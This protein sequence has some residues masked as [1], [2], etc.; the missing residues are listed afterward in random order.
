MA[1]SCVIC[2]HVKNSKGEM[3]ESRLFKGLLHHLADRGLAKEYYAV[4]T[5]NE[6]LKRVGDAAEFDENGEITVASLIKTAKI[7]IAKEK[8]IATLNEDIGA[9]VYSY[10]DAIG[11]LQNFNR[12]SPF[13]GD[14]MATVTSTGDGNYRL[15]VVERTA[16]NEGR[17]TAE[18]SNRT[19]QDRI[20]Y[21]LR[22]A[23]V[24]VDFIEADERI[25]GRYSTK[26]AKQTANG[27]YQLIKVAKGE[28]IDSSLAEEAGHFAVGALGK[29][30]LVQRFQKLLTPEVQKRILGE[31][32]DEKALG[33]NAAREVAGTL[34]GKALIGEVSNSV[35]GR[36]L[37]DRIVN[38][39]KKIFA[40]VKGDEVMKAALEADEIAQ[41]IAKDFLSPNFSGNVETALQTEETLYSARNSVNVATFKRVAK[42]LELQAA[43]MRRIDE[44]LRK[45]FDDIVL[46]TTLGRDVSTPSIWADVTSFDGIVQAVESMIQLLPEIG[47]TI[48]SIDFSNDLDFYSN[49][50][51][52]AKALRVI[53]TYLQNGRIIV[54]ILNDAIS[55]IA[56]SPALITGD[57]DQLRSLVSQLSAIV[58]GGG[59]NSLVSQ[60]KTKQTQF[61]LRFMENQYGSAFV[62]RA[63]RKVWNIG[64]GP[65]LVNVDAEQVPLADYLDFLSEDIS[66]YESLFSSMSN[67]PDVVGQIADKT[68]KQ[69]NKMADD[70]TLENFEELKRIKAI[71]DAAKFKPS[72]MRKCYEVNREG[73]LSGYFISS[74]LWGDWEKD[75]KAFRKEEFEKFKAMNPDITS[76]TISQQEKDFMWEQYFAPI[77]KAW[78]QANS[79]W[80]A[81]KE[82]YEPKDE[83]YHN[84]AFD[85]FVAE[86]PE[87][88]SILR[89]ILAM[90]E[91]LDQR[92]PEGMTRALKAPQFRGTFTNEVGNRGLYE[93]G[94]SAVGQTLR[95][96]LANTFVV[97]SEDRD[98]G[99][100]MTYEAEEDLFET[101][102]SK[103]KERLSR[104]PTYGIHLLPDMDELS[105]DFFHSMLSYAGMVNTYA[106]MTQ[107]VDTLEVGRETIRNRR[108]EGMQD[109]KGRDIAASR[110][111][112]R[113]G[114]FMEKQVYGIGYSGLKT[115]AGKSLAK[116]GAS[117][118]SL[119]AKVYLG[120]NVVGG[121]VNLGTGFLE[122]MKE[123]LSGEHFTMKEWRKAN[124]QY[125]ASLP[126]NLWD[127][128]KFIKDDKVSLI[129]NKFN[130][131]GDIKR[132][133]REWHTNRGRIRNFFG[134]SLM[135]P[136]KSGDHYMQAISYLA[137]LDGTKVYDIYG[138]EMTLWDAY[139]VVDIDPSNPKAGKK[140]QLKDGVV[141]KEEA[142][143]DTYNIIQ[144]IIS[145]I[146]D[147]LA[148]S[149]SSPF[150]G[151]ISLT[152]EEQD[153]LDSEG[154]NLADMEETKRALQDDA[155]QLTWNTADESAFMDKAREINNRLHGIYNNQDKVALQQ[156]IF[157]NM[158]MAMRG[159]AL[160]M[161]ERRFGRSK[162]NTMIGGEVEG[163]VNTFAKVVAST[164]TDQG[165]FLETMKYVFLPVVLGD[166]V[167]ADMEAH[168]FSA[169]QYYNMRRNFGD[170]MV[171]GLLA[172]LKYLTR[173]GARGDDDDD[174]YTDEDTAAG[175]AYY[176]SSRL[177]REQAAF[178]L[179]TGAYLE[180]NNLL[181]LNPAGF[182]VIYT[183]SNMA[184]L[185]V[186]QNFADEDDATYFYQSSKEGLY[187]EG[188]SKFWK[189]FDRMFPYLRSVYIFEHPY[190]AMESYDYGQRLRQR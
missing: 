122:I 52:N 3:V 186:G 39:A 103:E 53:S 25:D 64:R 116:V 50:P 149:S 41:R 61:F 151:A 165:G 131:Q 141:F 71:F 24:D 91:E 128:G 117:L 170:M 112:T 162:Y 33:P 10:N 90:K 75:F 99:N 150:G 172:L 144:S 78:H 49:M 62:E 1:D 60:F 45:K 139:Q 11:K 159:Y 29:S 6:F 96:N 180:K 32:Y 44:R 189:K 167:K 182:S 185:G 69:A 111:F 87:L 107:V 143:I 54:D 176:F 160:G 14:Y 168:G 100:D 124:Q 4:G 43:Q 20:L 175:L 70:L 187:E 110:A 34:V 137:I 181:D 81:E 67:S 125:F 38:V 5:D 115:K 164:F 83:V 129:M 154:Y 40:T 95:R 12:T 85:E 17:L 76:T 145:K 188:D 77:R 16:E 166:K 7:D 94:I 158:L 8:V 74:K 68:T 15:Q 89:Q 142:S 63:A 2:P 65:L 36:N 119:A 134:N 35:P 179:P 106:A 42:Q 18:I 23:G 59:T 120:G 93:G 82:C 133:Q 136:Y 22:E 114:K 73:K 58:N 26:N 161:I 113:Y 121:M 47:D 37:L 105:T 102:L 163:S 31:D 156:N 80:N 55:G 138:R 21:A 126:A 57:V 155:E 135:M 48:E 118:S 184:K 72:D 169:N 66:W 88:Y 97:T 9:G 130:A 174:K 147:S 146:N 104:V 123:A 13:K 27:L 148:A 101:S 177:Y 92:L 84:Y 86:N 108:V 140:L 173:P 153:Y 183:L 19:L 79:S 157:G 30:P 190:T 109:E 28:H 98:F 152:T 132:E 46:E 127:T 56:G 51:R 171:I 178:N